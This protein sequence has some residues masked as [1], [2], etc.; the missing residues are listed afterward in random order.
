[1]EHREF[2]FPVTKHVRLHARQFA[3]FA[4]LEEQFFGNG[5]CCTVHNFAKPCR[6][7]LLENFSLKPEDLTTEN[8]PS[9]ACKVKRSRAQ[10]S[11][12]Y[13]RPLTVSILIFRRSE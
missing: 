12:C 8:C 3:H 1:R 2:R 6:K 4:Y 11:P 5:Y 9:V 10:L 7:K 13:L